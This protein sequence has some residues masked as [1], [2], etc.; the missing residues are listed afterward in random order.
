YASFWKE[1][2][3]VL[4]EGPAED[5]ANR[6]RIA[7][8]LRFASTNS[9]GSQQSVSLEEYVGRMKEGQKEIY[10]VIADSYAAARSSPH[11][12][13]LRN[14]GVEVLLL[15]D[16]V[17]EWLTDHLREFDGKA[18]RNVARGQLDLDGVQS[19]EEKKAQETLSKEHAAVVERIGK[20]LG[21]RVSE[22]RVTARLTDSPAC[23]VLG[24]HDMGLQMRRILE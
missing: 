24:E 4:K 8:L 17:D 6:D 23:L 22:V 12:E 15:A 10:Y 20:A 13:V 11:L 9:E 21:E 1:F 18:L 2:G 3:A 19:E 5:H 7:R 14:K 16:R